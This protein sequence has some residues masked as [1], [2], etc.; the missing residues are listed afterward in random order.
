[1]PLKDLMQNQLSTSDLSDITKA[2]DQ[3]QTAITGK[4]VNLTQRNARNTAVLTS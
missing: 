2:M 3:L 1:M 4:M